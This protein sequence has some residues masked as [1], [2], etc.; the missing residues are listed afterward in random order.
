MVSTKAASLQWR[1]H[2]HA[3]E[4]ISFLLKRVT[5]S[6]RRAVCIFGDEFDLFQHVSSLSHF[7][8]KFPWTQNHFLT[9][10]THQPLTQSTEALRTAPK[11][12]SRCEMLQLLFNEQVCPHVPVSLF[13]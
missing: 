1:T 5:L 13:K 6:K 7:H 10:F 12:P 8:S 2:H 4:N 11:S 3:Q 9:N